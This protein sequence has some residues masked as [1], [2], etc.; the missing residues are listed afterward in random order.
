L[1]CSLKLRLINQADSKVLGLIV[2]VHPNRDTLG[3][4]LSPS[5]L[6]TDRQTRAA[7]WPVSDLSLVQVPPEVAKS[8]NS[9]IREQ[10]K[11][12]AFSN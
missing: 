4:V 6:V 10:I 9:R 1:R 12:E 3:V 2:F 7:F 8:K 5:E 11:T